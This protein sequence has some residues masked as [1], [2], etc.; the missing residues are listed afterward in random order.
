MMMTLTMDYD[1]AE[2]KAGSALGTGSM[3][4]MD[5]TTCMVQDAASASR[6]STTP[7]R[8]ASARRAAKAPAG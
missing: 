8:A 4:V 2:S 3:I 5:E 1:S 7:S 6:A